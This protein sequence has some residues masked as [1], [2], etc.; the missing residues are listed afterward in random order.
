MV[1]PVLSDCV[2]G[3]QGQYDR[4]GVGFVVWSLLTAGVEFGSADLLGVQFLVL[5]L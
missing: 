2:C 3:F 4:S 5:G 1:E